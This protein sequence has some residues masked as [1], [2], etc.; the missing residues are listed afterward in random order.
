M[1]RWRAVMELRAQGMTLERCWPSASAVMDGTEAAGA[2]DTI[3][4]SFRIIER[5]G[6]ERATLESYRSAV[7]RRPRR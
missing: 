5:A 7:R 3:R 4:D 6:G 2:V 1:A